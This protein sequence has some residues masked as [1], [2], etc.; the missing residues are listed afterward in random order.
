MNQLIEITVWIHIA[1]GSV[2]LVAFWLP[3]FA[4][5]G[6]RVHRVAGQVF[7]GSAYGVL[8]AAAITVTLRIAQLLNAGQGPAE[9]GEAW[10]FV[11]FLAYLTLVT[12][13]MINFGIGV[14]QHKRDLRTMKRFGVRLQAYLAAAAS[15]GIVAWG[16]Y[17]QPQN[18]ILLYALAPI[19]ILNAIN[20]LR[21]ISGESSRQQWLLEHLG[22]MLG[23]GIAYHTAF[24]V[25]GANRWFDFSHS[26]WLS[27]VP[28]VLPSALGIPA[29]IIWSRHY[30]NKAQA[31]GLPKA[32]L[33][34]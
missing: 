29:I 11:L 19:G 13:V 28:W 32:S 12:W 31:R 6:G 5:K 20:I 8:S 17:W 9:R 24:A 25:F 10:A 22:A 4:R 21:S 18:A 7:R 16:L 27:V 3:V 33:R 34:H 30:R 26:G 23:C 15:V 14:L 1:F 2:G